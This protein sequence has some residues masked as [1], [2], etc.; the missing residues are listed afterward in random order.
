MWRARLR[1]KLSLMNAFLPY[2]RPI[3]PLD[4]WAELDS[5]AGDG[6]EVSLMWSRAA[7]RVKVAVRDLRAGRD[8]DVHVD[9]RKALEAFHHPFAFA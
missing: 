4:D 6:L 2:P 8:F 3:E 5:R 9:S 1:R 7:D